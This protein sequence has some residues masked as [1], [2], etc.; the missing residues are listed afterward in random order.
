M[1]ENLMMMFDLSRIISEETLLRERL[2]ETLAC[3]GQGDDF[4]RKLCSIITVTRTFQ[5]H[6]EHLMTMKERDGYMGAVLETH[7]NLSNAV[8]ALRHEHDD[9][10]E[11]LA[12][13]LSR[14]ERI[15][16]KDQTCLTQICDDLTDVLRKVD[17]HNMNESDL[18]HEA[19]EREDGGEG[20][21]CRG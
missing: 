19:F 11:E 9:F 3:N 5:T 10:R 18:F 6:M 1:E 16:L 17:G 13:V 14:L 20:F 4:G 15:S 2:Q 21:D 7:P 12:L 8:E